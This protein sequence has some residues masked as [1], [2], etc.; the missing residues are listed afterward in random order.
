MNAVKSRQMAIQLRPYQ[1]R[2]LDK[3]M[4]VHHGKVVIPTGGGKTVVMSHHAIELINNAERPMTFLVSSP[5]IQLTIQLAN[6]FKQFIPT[7]EILHVHS[8]SVDG[9]STTKPDMIRLWNNRNQNKH[10]FIFS[11]YNSL[12][13][14]N[15]SGIDVDCFYFD[16]CHH[17]VKP[18]F[19]DAV[20]N[21]VPNVD[22]KYFFTATVRNSED[23]YARGMNNTSIYGNLIDS[24]TAPELVNGGAILRPTVVSHIVK[25]SSLTGITQ[26]QCDRDVLLQMIDSLSE[27]ETSKILVAAPSSKS[28]WNLL[29]HTDCKNELI[30]RGYNVLHITSKFGAWVNNEKVSRRV[31]FEI[32]NIWAKCPNTKFVIFHY[33]IL[34]EGIDIPGLSHCF[35]LRNLPLIDMAQ[36][37]GR[38]I[39]MHPNDVSAI[40]SGEIEAGDCDCYY[41]KTG[42]VTVPISSSIKN[43]R[44]TIDRLNHMVHD[45]FVKGKFVEVK[46]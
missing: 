45:L 44:A 15:T 23:P 8:G 20:R 34:S 3:M 13:R 12:H 25:D 18:A 40:Q 7:A 46:K 5:R 29:S 43:S 24:V 22:Y 37:I 32:L 21:L 17:T 14:I 33:S 28:I 19:F 26:E 30:K 36:T 39:R 31:F 6:N 35:L 9:I 4:A 16:E 2:A 1:Q 38:V 10:R 42:F 27:E 11:T 41:K